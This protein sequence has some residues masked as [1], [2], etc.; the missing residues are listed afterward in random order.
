MAPPDTKLARPSLPCRRS[1]ASLTEQQAWIET[2]VHWRTAAVGKENASTAV[3]AVPDGTA[4]NPGSNWA[5]LIVEGRLSPA[6]GLS[7][8]ALS[9][10]SLQLTQPV[11]QPASASGRQSQC[12]FKSAHLEQPAVEA[13]DAQRLGAAI[14]TWRGQSE[15]GTDASNGSPG[16]GTASPATAV[17]R[18]QLPSPGSD[19]APSPP[20]GLHSPLAQMQPRGLEPALSVPLRTSE[21][22]AQA[23][24]AE[25]YPPIQ[26][27]SPS[28]VDSI[29]TV[30]PGTNISPPASP[31]PLPAAIVAGGNDQGIARHQWAGSALAAQQVAAAQQP[32][33]QEAELQLQQVAEL[34]CEHLWTAVMNGG[35]EESQERAAQHYVHRALAIT[36]QVRDNE[37]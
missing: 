11:W 29:W 34:R 33:Q 31:R 4:T 2:L 21:F 3:P 28:G 9:P 14:Q 32:Q 8:R 7:P 35:S 13:V 10:V 5:A 16:G 12:S 37:H 24:L 20:W 30:P 27:Q 17:L 1:G 25:K 23:L 36:F 22:D 6:G 18:V 15:P 26:H 19:P